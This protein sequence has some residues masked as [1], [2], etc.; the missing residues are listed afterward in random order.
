MRRRARRVIVGVDGLPHSNAALRWAADEARLRGCE[1]VL[2]TVCNEG[3]P[4][5]HSRLIAGLPAEPPVPTSTRVLR[6]DPA[7]ALTQAAGAD[8]LLVLGTRGRGT[9]KTLALGSVARGCI[10]RTSRPV[11]VV[12]PEAATTANACLRGPVVVGVDETPAAQHA[13]HFAAEEAQ[14][15]RVP[16]LVVHVLDPAYLGAGSGAGG[17][18]PRGLLT[19]LDSAAAEL[20]SYVRTE[21]RGYDIDTTSIATLG[22]PAEELLEWAQSATLLVVGTRGT[23]RVAAALLGS[24]SADILHRTV[25]PTG[26]VPAPAHELA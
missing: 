25:C 12:P 2:V 20:E 4:H 15:R 26:V 7:K 10:A 1:P 18:A 13:L 3:C 17:G 19:P 21:T 11:V 23:G 14:L 16:L 6:G 22:S 5:M 24:T 9:L 8:D